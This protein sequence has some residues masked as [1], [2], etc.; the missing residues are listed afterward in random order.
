MRVTTKA[1]RGNA[2]FV[3][4]FEVKVVEGPDRNATAVSHADELTIGSA[5]GADLRLTDPSVSRHHCSVRASERGLELRDLGSTNGTFVGENEIVRAFVRTGTRAKLGNT[6]IQ[7][8]V[9]DREVEHPLAAADRFGDLVGGSPVMRRL[10]PLLEQCAKSDASVVI[11]G[12]TGTGKELVAEAIHAASQRHA[13]PFVVVDCGALPRQLTESELFGHVHGAF[14]GADTD[15]I[16]AFEEASG[17]TIFLDEIGEL[18]LE[19]QPLLLRA[20]E[21]RTIRR[22]GTNQQRPVDVRVIAAS[23]RDLRVEVNQ[24]RFRADLFYRLNVLR[25]QVPA[26]VDRVGDIPLLASHFWRMLRPE[27]PVPGDLLAGLAIQSW[28]GNVRE[29]RNAVERI[30]LMGGTPIAADSD[31]LSFG[32]ARQRASW[33]WERHWIQRLL[34]ANDH[35]VSRAARAAQMGRSH[36]RRL[37][38]RH[39]MTRPDDETDDDDD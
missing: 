30:A 15:R 19:L 4:Q 28:P 29:L 24:K 8:T 1:V 27:V 20:L 37:M 5:D 11:E 33:D 32:E 9:L 6:T 14:T 18:P 26:L 35:N 22:V 2:V 38:Q 31:N 36:L 16:G 7:I 21:N 10:Y 12:D 23:H 17:G 39:K 13:G 34:A 3:R 25:I